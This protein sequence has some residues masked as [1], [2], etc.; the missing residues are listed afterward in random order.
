MK[1]TI[2][3]GAGR[4]AELICYYMEHYK[5]HEIE[6]FAV[7]QKYLKKTKLMERPVVVYETIQELY[8]PSKYNLFIAIGAQNI[9]QERERLY[10][11]AKTKSYKLVNCICPN[12]NIS[13][14]SIYGDNVFIGPSSGIS[15]FV[16]IGN[17]VSIS[18]ASIGHH[19]EIKDNVFLVSCVV[20]AGAQIHKNVFVGIN[21][22]I[23]PNLVIKE[24][25]FIGMG[26]V[27]TKQVDAYSV[28]T[29]TKSTQKRRITSDKIKIK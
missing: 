3:V 7:E 29:N 14:N 26:C 16:T 10:Q 1:K 6:A 15:P 24:G 18:D 23:T 13:P 27:V 20:G 5:L 8:P 11:D 12:P 19:C 17:N 28:Y 21:S 9:N 22:S 2:I 4:Q 25:S